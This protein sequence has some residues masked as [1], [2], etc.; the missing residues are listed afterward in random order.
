MNWV[1]RNSL[2]G[3]TI[4]ML[5]SAAHAQVQTVR[6]NIS[7]RDNSINEQGFHLERCIGVGC[8]NFA[9]IGGDLAVN[10]TTYQ[11]T[12][13]DDSGNRMICY[14]IKAFNSTGEST[15]SNT[16][17]VTTPPITP[18]PAPTVLT[19]SPISESSLLVKWKDNSKN[20]TA[21]QIERDGV[22]IASTVADV[23][24]F[25]DTGLRR[26]HRYTYRVRAHNQFANSQWTPR[27]SGRTL[28]KPPPMPLVK[29]GETVPAAPG[30]R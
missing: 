2:T 25:N 21:F 4:V 10:S 28:Q 16:G 23:Q 14:R 27:V 7:W 13:L 29:P 30:I 6:F 8:T 17:C 9:K 3:L 12:I 1:R 19:V 5:A 24:Y 22:I 18:P 11:D 26:N 15:P 20:E